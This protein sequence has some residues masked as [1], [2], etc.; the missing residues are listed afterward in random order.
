MGV[1]GGG[2]R[3]LKPKGDAEICSLIEKYSFSARAVDE[4]SMP[5]ARD[6]GARNDTAGYKKTKIGHSNDVAR[7]RGGSGWVKF[8]LNRRFSPVE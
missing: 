4:G 8:Y 6:Q 1:V 3:V 7:F 2:W 5:V